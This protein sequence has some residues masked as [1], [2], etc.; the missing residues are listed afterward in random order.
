LVPN[1]IGAADRVADMIGVV[2]W[3]IVIFILAL[4]VY[5]VFAAIFGGAGLFAA[6][7]IG[8]YAIGQSVV[9]W[10]VFGW[11]QHTLGMLVNIASTSVPA[12]MV[13]KGKTV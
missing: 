10:A 9:A 5:G 7:G 1:D 4:G 2:K 12:A 3:L 13:D 11:F 8:L 6:I